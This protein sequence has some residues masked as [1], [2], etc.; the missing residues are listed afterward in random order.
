MRTRILGMIAATV[1]LAAY[2][3]P[4]QE[5]TLDVGGMTCASCP[6]TVKAVLKKQSGVADA[7]VDLD[8]HA[9]RVKFDPA[10]VSAEQLARAV[11]EAGFPAK[12]AK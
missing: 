5:V 7:K 6:L 3:A 11:S 9:A 10:L 12:V 2:A 1:A 4:Q 8:R